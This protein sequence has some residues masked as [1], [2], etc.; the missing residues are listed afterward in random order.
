MGCKNRTTKLGLEIESLP[1]P[2]QLYCRIKKAFQNLE[3]II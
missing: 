1:L 2:E 3:N